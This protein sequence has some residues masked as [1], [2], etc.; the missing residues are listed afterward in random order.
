L[1]LARLISSA[2]ST[3]AKIGPGWNTKVSLPRS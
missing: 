3:C 1:G 2:S